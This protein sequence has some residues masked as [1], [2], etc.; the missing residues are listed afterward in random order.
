MKKEINAILFLFLAT[1]F[2]GGTFPIIK[3]AVAFVA[4][5]VFVT[6]RFALAAIILLPFAIKEYHH[7]SWKTV[8]AGMILGGLNGGL[9]LLQTLSV[10]TIDA[11]QAAFISG[12]A[13][14]LVP[15]I[16]AWLKVAKL[17]WIDLAAAAA[18]LVGLFIFTRLALNIHSGSF[19]CLLSTICAALNVIY[20]QIT[21]RRNIH[22]L[23]VLTFYQILFT[24]PIPAVLSLSANYH[25]I[26]TLHAL[27]GILFCA[28]F[29]TSIA[30]LLQTKYQHF[31]NPNKAT[32]IYTLEP[33]FAM[34]IAWGIG[35]QS[36]TIGMII[37]GIIMLGSILL[38]AFVIKQHHWWE[39]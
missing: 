30:L 7:H 31:V 39:I 16:A 4:P 35:Q 2:W 36:I 14:I 8:K 33:V 15:F 22:S 25:N 12:S 18:C 21:T 24:L 34:I 38:R 27:I 19:W 26:F 28:I 37:G 1:A 32:L 10:E 5:T 9:Y 23:F 6:L 29:A 11:A 20:L 17:R 3:N 13:V